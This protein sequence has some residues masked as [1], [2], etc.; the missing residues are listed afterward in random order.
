MITIP[1]TVV[2]KAS[3]VD[4]QDLDQR[5]QNLTQYEIDFVESIMH[6]LKIGR[7]LTDRQR[8]KL[9]DIREKRL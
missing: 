3:W 8:A 9:D 2:D 7:M 6:Q 5:G 1:A 4:L